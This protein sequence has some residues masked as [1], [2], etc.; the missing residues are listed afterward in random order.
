MTFSRIRI[1]ESDWRIANWREVFFRRVRTIRPPAR[2]VMLLQWLMGWRRGSAF[3]MN[4]DVDG[5][6]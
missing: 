4:F 5:S 6:V 3:Q 1:V 2:E